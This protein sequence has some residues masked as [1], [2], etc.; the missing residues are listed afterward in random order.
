MDAEISVQTSTLPLDENLEPK[1]AFNA[2]PSMFLRISVI[3]VPLMTFCAQ[4]WSLILVAL[5]GA[6][7]HPVQITQMVGSLIGVFLFPLLVVGLFQIGKRFRNPR[8]RYR[9][10]LFTALFSLFS[11]LFLLFVNFLARVG[12][13]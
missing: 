10:F 5:L 8:S 6:A 11:T 12:S 7:I 3:I 4:N 1:A 9:I 13:A 2:K